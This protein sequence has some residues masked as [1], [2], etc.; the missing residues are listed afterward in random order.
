MERTE[1][2]PR[3]LFIGGIP[4]WGITADHLRY[5]F[6][7]YGNVV[8]ALVML[9]P[10]GMCRGFGFVEFED[11]EAALR[12]LD[13][14]QRDAHDAFFGRKVDVKKAE[15][16]HGNRSA[17]AQSPTC[18]QHTDKKKIFVGGLGDKITKDDL[19]NYF[20]MFGKITDAIVFNDKLTRKARGFGFVTFDSQEAADKVLEKSFY[21]L[22]GTRVET[23]RAEPRG[24][25]GRGQRSPANNYGGMFSPHNIPF[26]SYSPF[27]VLYPYPYLY[28]YAACG[29]INYEYMMNQIDILPEIY[30]NYGRSY[31][32]IASVKF[33]SDN[34]A[35]ENHQT[36]DI[37]AST[38]MKSDPGELDSNLL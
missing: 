31:R 2:E 8:E 25:M 33:E 23:K 30:A 15:K 13:V 11:E 35:K 17:P 22:K 37:S 38:G 6:A 10:N 34:K 32:S 26:A 36:V 19:S 1:L 20:G 18:Y 28:P 5:H 16:K 9:L 21:F 14:R 27:P 3:K 7:R 12:A 24:S 4:H 29:N